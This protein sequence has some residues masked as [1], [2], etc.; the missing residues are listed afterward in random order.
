GERELAIARDLLCCMG[1][2][3]SSNGNLESQQPGDIASD[4]IAWSAPPVFRPGR[5]AR[6]RTVQRRHP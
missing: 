3:W 6:R 2:S 4:G 1:S 5:V